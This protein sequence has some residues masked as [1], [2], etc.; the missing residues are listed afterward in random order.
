VSQPRLRLA[1][2]PVAGLKLTLN[3]KRFEPGVLGLLAPSLGTDLE[4]TL[5]RDGISVWHAGKR[6]G[7]DPQTFVRLACVLARVGPHGGWALSLQ[8]EGLTQGAPS[9]SKHERLC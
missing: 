8:L 6:Q 1:E 4:G 9:L 3:P 2:R 5:A 7:L